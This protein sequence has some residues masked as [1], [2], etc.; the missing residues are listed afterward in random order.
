MIINFGTNVK[1][2]KTGVIKNAICPNCNSKNELIYSIYGGYVNL[3]I[4]PTA[5][6][7][8]TIIAECNNCKKTYKLNELDENI[9][10]NFKLQYKEDPVKTPLWQYT[11]LVIL[12][13]VLSF[14]IYTGIMATKAE[15][16]YIIN[17]KIGDIYRINNNSVYT[18][19]KVNKI[20]KDSVSIF[21]ND[22]ETSG[23]SGIDEINN[24]KNY[25]K[26]KSFSKEELREMYNQ[27]IIYQIDRP[28]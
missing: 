20:L 25:N 6:I 16:V 12:V 8:K 1:K 22:M 24:D 3:V 7:K 19:L 27:N 15:K 18:T 13:F 26:L 14:A 4:I 9:K 11:G 17:P 10:R 28:E 2:L 5:P 23:Y 21:I